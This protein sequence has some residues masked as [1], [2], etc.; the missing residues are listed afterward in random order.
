MG[1]WPSLAFEGNRERFHRKVADA[2]GELTWN[3]A[4]GA[5]PLAPTRVTFLGRGAHTLGARNQLI[6][7][8]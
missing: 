4:I 8:F 3:Q 6:F 5:K 2:Q 1:R 7:E